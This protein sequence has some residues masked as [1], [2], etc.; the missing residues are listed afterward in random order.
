RRA[1]GDR[2]MEVG[3]R[4]P[5]PLVAGGVEHRE[6]ED[7]ICVCPVLDRVGHTVAAATSVLTQL[8]DRTAKEGGGLVEASELLLLDPLGGELGCEAFEL[9]PH[10][11]RL[12]DLPC[13]RLANDCA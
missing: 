12:P 1:G 4:A 5:Q 11:V 10:F 3:Q 8:V 7:V 2:A 9:G 6:V 13:V